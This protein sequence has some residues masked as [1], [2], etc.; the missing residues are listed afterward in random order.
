MGQIDLR[1]TIEGAKVENI[2]FLQD[3]W[4]EKKLLITVCG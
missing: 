3:E 2:F 4:R 1:F